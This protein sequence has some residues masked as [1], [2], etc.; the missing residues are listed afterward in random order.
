MCR[1]YPGGDT[2]SFTTVRHIIP[3]PVEKNLLFK[4]FI[5][6]HLRD[7]SVLMWFL[8]M[9][10]FVGVFVTG[11]NVFFG[12]R[13]Y[14]AAEEDFFKNQQGLWVPDRVNYLHVL[15]KQGKRGGWCVSSFFVKF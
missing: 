13:F 4:I 14:L 11:D 12:R 8:F 5:F 10:I 7:S 15:R 9:K 3:K 6:S 2:L 1:R